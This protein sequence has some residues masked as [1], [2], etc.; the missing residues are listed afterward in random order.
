MV[1]HL[2]LA[3]KLVDKKRMRL[4]MHGISVLSHDEEARNRK[5]THTLYE[6]EDWQNALEGS[7]RCVWHASLNKV[8]RIKCDASWKIWMMQRACRAMWQQSA[9]Q[10]RLFNCLIL[11]KRHWMTRCQAASH[12]Y[13]LVGHICTYP[14]DMSASR[15]SGSTTSPVSLV[16]LYC[17]T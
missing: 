17:V 10:T 1:S 5:S 14:F 2:W 4:A 11:A 12:Q 16:A 7:A 8:K 9:I 3:G 15:L 6:C 13:E